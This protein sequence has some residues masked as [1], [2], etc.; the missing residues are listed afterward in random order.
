M[1]HFGRQLVWGFILGLFSICL[2][3]SAK[4]Q[5]LQNYRLEVLSYN[6]KGLPWPVGTVNGKSAKKR[7]KLIGEE[8]AELRRLGTA[9]QVVV[10]Q[11]MMVEDCDQLLIRSGYPHS[12]WQVKEEGRTY[13]TGLAFLSEFPLQGLQKILYGNNCSGTDCWAHKGVIGVKVTIPE[14]PEP[15]AIVTTHLQAGRENDDIRLKQMDQMIGEFLPLMGVSH[16]V[17]IFAG[18][19]NSK[20]SRPSYDYFLNLSGLFDAGQVCLKSTLSCQSVFG[21]RSEPENIWE[22]THDRQFFHVPSASVLR[23]FPTQVLLRFSGD[24]VLGPELSD[25]FGYQV[26]YIISWP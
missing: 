6:V 19:F 18:D 9:P 22:D 13:G 5:V 25:H 7:C 12:Y 10:L 23:M 15:V 4:S 20:P 11:E 8:L 26:D 14:L 21:G 17:Q 16:L 1:Q 24:P 3:H 2:A